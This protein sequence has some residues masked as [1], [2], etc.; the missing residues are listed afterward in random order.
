[1]FGHASHFVHVHCTNTVHEP[2]CTVYC[3]SIFFSMEKEYLQYTLPICWQVT[4]LF[5]G[6]HSKM[7]GLQ[8]CC[9][10]FCI[11]GCQSWILQ[12]C[13]Y[14]MMFVHQHCFTVW[15]RK[16]E[17]NIALSQGTLQKPRFTSNRFFFLI[18]NQ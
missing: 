4:D 15:L 12:S 14:M 13:F 7:I 2:Y 10:P 17:L 1:M 11:S 3:T 6:C 8:V 9:L 18:T 5:P 16:P